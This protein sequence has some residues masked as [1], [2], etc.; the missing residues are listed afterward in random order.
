MKRE[1]T[2]NTHLPLDAASTFARWDWPRNT[3]YIAAID[4][5]IG[6]SLVS[7]IVAG[8]RLVLYR[9][10]NGQPVA[11]E[12]ACW[13]RL[14]PLSKGNLKGDVVACGYHGLEFNPEGHCVFMPSQ[15]TVNPA[16]RVRSFPIVERNRFIWVWI[17]DPLLANPC[18]VPDLFW[19]GHADWTGDGEWL[20]VDCSYRLVVDNLMDLTHE[21]YVHRQHRERSDCRG[22]LRCAPWR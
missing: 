5:E 1:S 20:H 9:R 18:K 21:T 22:T 6:R 3:W 13:H 10:L 14:V 4:V 7:R 19:N 15:D 17:G 16:A 12:D 8:K 2:V 11:L